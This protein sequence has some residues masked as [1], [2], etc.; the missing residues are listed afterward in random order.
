MKKNIAMRVA[1]ILF[2]LTMISTCAFSTTFAKYVT[3]AN[4]EDSAR[5]AKW[6][7]VISPQAPT[8]SAFSATYEK[9]DTTCTFTNTVDGGSEK[10]MA[11]GT[12]GSL[13]YFDV[14]GSPEVAVRVS[15][16]STVEIS[17]SWEDGDG[18]YYCPVK[19]TV[20]YNSKS[21]VVDGFTCTSATDLAS[22]L[23][24]AIDA[25]TGD[26]EARTNLQT[27]KACDLN[28][29][30]EW[31]F[32]T[33]STDIEKAANNVKDTFLGNLATAPKVSLSVTCTVTQID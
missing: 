6:G 22:K 3:S 24:A 33:G 2:I 26:Y 28:I 29:A 16:N 11:P 31:A 9:T 14:T 25:C 17:E 12:G 19:F 10:V 8:R 30:W 23:K 15:Y 21:T 5:V 18:N 1:A 7:V 20:T 13:I 32:E 27:A 4:T